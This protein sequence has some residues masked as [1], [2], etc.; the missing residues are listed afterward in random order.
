MSSKITIAVPI[1]GV[2]KHIERCV[3]SLFE[4]TCEDIEYIFVDDCS[5]DNSINI[6]YDVMKEYPQ[7]VNHI[8]IIQHKHNRGLG[9]ARNTAV[10]NCSTEFIMHVDSDDYIASCTIEK[11]LQ[12]QE[13]TGADIISFNYMTI[14][15]N[16][17]ITKHIFDVP[18]DINEWKLQILRRNYKS[19]IWSLLIRTSLYTD[20]DIK[21]VE[22]INMGE[23]YQV[24]PL[25]FYFAKKIVSIDDFLYFYIKNDNSYTSSFNIEKAKQSLKSVDILKHFFKGKGVEY[26]EA[27]IQGETLTMAMYMIGCARANQKEFAEHLKVKM[28]TIPK[29]Y[30]RRIPFNYQI[31][32]YFR[33]FLLLHY[34]SLIGHKIKQLVK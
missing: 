29:K 8:R 22:G 3:R 13:E 14:H 28:Q 17:S 20:N 4:Q 33:N 6:L 19:V 10:D 7:R 5:P 1:Y 15:G 31:T 27:I 11:A 2:E 30:I 25:L 34:Y 26:E 18:T 32:Y 9:A 21:V 12:K 23:D 24:S 16:G